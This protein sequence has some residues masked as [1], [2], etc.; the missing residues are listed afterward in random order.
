MPRLWLAIRPEALG[1]FCLLTGGG[2]K[3]G[4][5]AAQSVREFLS[6]PLGLAPDHLARIQT[7][8]LDFRA[9]DDLD[10]PR[11]VAGSTV[12]LSAA[13]PGI[14]GAILRMGSPYRPMRSQISHQ[15]TPAETG[16]GQAGDVTVKVFNLLQQELAPQFLQRGIRISGKAFG[17]FLRRRAAS[18]QSAIVQ[19]RIAAATEERPLPVE[20]LLSM[21]WVEQEILL[22][23][24]I[25]AR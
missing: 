6:G 17:E 2:F 13:M 5:D 12:G 4:I 20:V 7:V 10:T 9:V 16:E 24:G 22:R 8:F 19:A 15:A 25:P 23:V 3:V 11:V 18:L 1:G 14:A 21:D